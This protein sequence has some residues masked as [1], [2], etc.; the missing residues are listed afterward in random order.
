MKSIKSVLTHACLFAFLTFVFSCSSAGA[1][2]NA[3]TGMNYLGTT[4][5]DSLI[6][7]YLTLPDSTLIDF[8]KWDLTLHS[9]LTHDGTFVLHI[10]FGESQPNTLGFKGGG[11]KRSITGTYIIYQ[12][13][14]KNLRGEIYQLKSDEEPDFALSLVKLDDNLFH[15]LSS[16]NRLMVGN[17]GWSYTLN[18]KEVPINESGALPVLTSLSDRVDD[19]RLQVIFEG[20]TPCLDFARDH[21]L[22]V[23]SDCLKLKWKLTLNRDP[24]TLLPTTYQLKRTD[25][26]EV[27]ELT[28]KW[29]I[30]YGTRSN[31]GAIIYTLDPDKPERAISLLAGDENVIFFLNK[32]Y[33]LYVGNEDFSFTLNKRKQL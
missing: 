19:T 6:K 29:A 9:R 21:N 12:S 7:S 3:T 4:P 11:S 17:G 30:D 14:D 2:K 8:I 16:E 1:E 23:F 20:R 13:Q 24:V 28:G 22:A 25:I 31:P 10:G 32:N 18:R 5:G 33:Q 27:N 15:L 26:R